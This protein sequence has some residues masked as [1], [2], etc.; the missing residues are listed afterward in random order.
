M[1]K[2]EFLAL[3]T[4]EFLSP[5]LQNQT[6]VCQAREAADYLVTVTN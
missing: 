4:A 1:L 5:L 6:V 3:M 2:A